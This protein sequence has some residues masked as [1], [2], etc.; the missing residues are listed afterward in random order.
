M[1]IARPLVPSRLFTAILLA[2]AAT[3]VSIDP[4]GPPQR[5]TPPAPTATS[6]RVGDLPIEAQAAISASV[7]RESAAYRARSTADGWSLGNRAQQ[8]AVTLDHDG[9]IVRATDVEW[10][11]RLHAYG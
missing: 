3:S 5:P 6:Q 9:V 7:G 4:A 10:R 11:M 1:A 2:L 8:F